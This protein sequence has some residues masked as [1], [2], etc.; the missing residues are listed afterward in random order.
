MGILNKV[1]PSRDGVKTDTLSQAELTLLL[2]LIHNCSFDGKDV[3]L[4]ADA[5]EK[6]QNQLKSK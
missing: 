4:L 6:L 3:L 2:K 5:V 1:Q